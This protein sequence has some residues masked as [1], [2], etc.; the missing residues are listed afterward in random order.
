MQRALKSLDDNILGIQRRLDEAF[1]VQRVNHERLKDE[2]NTLLV[3]Q[4]K[5]RADDRLIRDEEWREHN[6]KYEQQVVRLEALEEAEKS[7][8]QLLVH[9]RSIDQERL[10]AVFSVMR[11]FMSEYDQDMKKVP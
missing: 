5:I 11:E 2:W 8:A 9:L 3:E 7:T 4:E 6:R 10:K 1:E